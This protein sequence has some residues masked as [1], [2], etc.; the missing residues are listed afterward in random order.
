MY[1][2]TPGRVNALRA[3][4]AAYQEQHMSRTDGPTWSGVEADGIVWPVLV[5]EVCAVVLRHK[6]QQLIPGPEQHEGST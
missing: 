5:V 6:V 2:Y 3:L 1:W 4:D